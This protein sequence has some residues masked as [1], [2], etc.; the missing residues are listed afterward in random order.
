M[1]FC[2]ETELLADGYHHVTRNSAQ[3]SLRIS[4]ILQD[5]WFKFFKC[6]NPIISYFKNSTRS[7]LLKN[8]ET[9]R[10]TGRDLPPYDSLPIFLRLPQL[11][12]VKART[13]NSV[14]VSHAGNKDP[15]S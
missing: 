15:R 7:F 2:L 6:N 8:K 4:F 11:G 5:D 3:K 10:D 1:S 9:G 14:Q 12:Q 13:R